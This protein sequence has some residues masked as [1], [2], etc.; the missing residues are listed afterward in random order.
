MS[1]Y[2]LIAK[3]M[4]KNRG[5]LKRIF[6]RKGLLYCSGKAASKE[7]FVLHVK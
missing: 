6:Q 5:L 2:N 7:E 3:Y 4:K 1:E